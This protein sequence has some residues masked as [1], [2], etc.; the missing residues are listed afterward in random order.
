MTM[1]RHLRTPSIA[2]ALLAL[3]IA[4]APALFPSNFYYEIGAS[5]FVTALAV[6]GLN[7]LMGYAGQVSLGHAAFFGIGGYAAAIGPEH[8][9]VPSLLS[10]VAGLA[11]SLAIAWLVGRPILR[12]K[13]HYLAVAT[14]GFGFLVSLVLA[15]EARWTG[16]PDGMSVARLDL[17]GLVIRGSRMWYWTSALVLLAGIW[18]ALNIVG[19]PTGRAWRALHD[20]EVAASVN[21]VDVARYKLAAFVISAGYASLAGS[22]AAFAD[23]HVTPT[24]AGFL[25]SIELVTMSVLGGMSSVFGAVLGAAVLKAL[26]QIL[27]FLHEYEQVVIGAI[28]I[29]IMIF[30]PQGIL[31]SLA[32][33]ARRRPA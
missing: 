30:L 20:S 12:L 17:L 25:H 31:P 14:L 16:G 24:S 7:L 29:C 15:N 22:L 28:M 5:I 4:V 13:G 11:L 8:F 23:G 21:G 33:L 9:G 27:T 3:L 19:S 26:P 6:V 32:A 18:L 2:V 1:A 10:L